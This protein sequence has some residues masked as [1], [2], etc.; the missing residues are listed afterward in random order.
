MKIKSRGY[1]L[2]WRDREERGR[3]GWRAGRSGGR[4]QSEEPGQ[5][6]FVGVAAEP[7]STWSRCWATNPIADACLVQVSSQTGHAYHLR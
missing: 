7:L 5:G 6:G 2:A 1:W 3:Q 4:E